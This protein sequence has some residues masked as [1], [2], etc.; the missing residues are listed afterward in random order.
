ME[1]T[2]RLNLQANPDN[3]LS[4]ILFNNETQ[5]I[6]RYRNELE[7]RLNISLPKEE[8]GLKIELERI[9]KSIKD[10]AREKDLLQN[11]INTIRE[12]KVLKSPFYSK[13]PIKPSIKKNIVR[14][15]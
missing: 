3:V 14:V 12:T 2:N 6:Q 15:E 7:D 8:L 10:T 5:S 1:E 13:I 4:S 11:Q 9:E